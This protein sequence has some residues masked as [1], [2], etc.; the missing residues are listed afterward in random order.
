MGRKFKRTGSVGNAFCSG[1]PRDT[2]TVENVYAVAQAVIEEPTQCTRH[3]T[4][5]LD[6]SRLVL[7]NKNLVMQKSGTFIF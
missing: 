7:H 6:L 1:Y 3:G 4:L 5:Q 2:C